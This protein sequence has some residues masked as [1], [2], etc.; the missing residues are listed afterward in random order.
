M[1]KKKSGEEEKVGS[2]HTKKTWDN[3]KQSINVVVVTI[4]KPA[5]PIHLTKLLKLACTTSINSDLL[6]G[7]YKQYYN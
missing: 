6:L 3:G 4:P 5:F 1:G 7:N 2:S